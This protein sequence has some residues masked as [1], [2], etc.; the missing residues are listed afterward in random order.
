MRNR[1]KKKR[2]KK[3]KETEID[4]EERRVKQE[5]EETQEAD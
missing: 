4:G 5:G 2:Y 3:N 1:K